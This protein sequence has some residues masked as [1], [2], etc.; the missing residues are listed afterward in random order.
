MSAKFT[1]GPWK[2]VAGSI[3]DSNGNYIAQACRLKSRD[4]SAANANL[5]EAGPE[6]LEALNKVADLAEHLLRTKEGIVALDAVVLAI[7][8]AIG[9]D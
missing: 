7:H 1:P 4:E 9:G 2:N 8:K 6:M 5:I 3:Y